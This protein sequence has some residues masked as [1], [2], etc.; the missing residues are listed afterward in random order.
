MDA[1][2]K[3]REHNTTNATDDVS[4]ALLAGYTVKAITGDFYTNIKITT[5]E[6]MELAKL[7]IKE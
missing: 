3:A 6:D 1:H 4:L 5:N 2:Q 7:L